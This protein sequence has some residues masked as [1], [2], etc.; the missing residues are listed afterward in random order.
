MPAGE[1]KGLRRGGRRGARPGRAEPPRRRR[2]ADSARG[3]RYPGDDGRV[4][5]GR[6]DGRRWPASRSS[7]PT[8][9]RR[10]TRSSAP[11]AKPDATPRPSP[12][13]PRN[14]STRWSGLTVR[15]SSGSPPAP[16]GRE[17][18]PRRWPAGPRR[19]RRGRPTSS[20]PIR[21]LGQRR[22]RSPADRAA[23]RRR[24]LR[25]DSA[26]PS[27]CT[28][29]SAATWAI[30]TPTCAWRARPSP[31]CPG[32]DWSPLRRSRRPQPLGG[33]AAAIV[34]QPDGAGGD[35][36]RA[37]GAA[38]G[39]ARR[40][41]IEPGES[42]ASGGGRARWT[43][44]SFATATG[45]STS[46]TLSFPIPSCPNRDFWQRELAELQ[47]DPMNAEGRPL[48]VLDLTAMKAAGRRDRGAHLLRRGLRPPAR[49]RRRWTCCSSATR[50]NQVLGR[51]RDDAQRDAGSD[52][53][54][55]GLRA[56]GARRGRW[57]S[58]ISRSS[59]IRSPSKTPSGTPA[60]CSRRAARTASSWRAGIRWPRRCARWWTAA[61]RSS[62]IS[63]SRR[64]RSTRSAGIGCRA[65]TPNA[66]MRSSVT[67]RRWRMPAR[68]PSC[69]SC[70]RRRWRRRIS[71][72]AHDSHHRDR[73]RTRMRRPGAGAPRHARAQRAVQSPKFLKHYAR[74]GE[75]V[76]QASRQFAQDVRDGKYPGPEHSFSR[77][78]AGR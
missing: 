44:T 29:R 71:E 43:S 77:S 39:A 56:D 75:T 42:A 38:G 9:R 60:G 21:E 17:A 31:P 16:P 54:S 24:D 36:A 18:T 49:S 78:Q 6:T 61:Y 27:G 69:S 53:L 15:R 45:A 1:G 62:A 57:C 23:L 72:V 10:S 50:C 11:P 20:A 47:A 55:R 51:P 59:P 14:S 2:G 8:P 34:P 76:R 13:R 41:R 5:D 37:A 22:V 66:P 63:V 12:S 26:R 65:G 4:P 19:R 28:S 7:A 48:H 30:G 58:W 74:A 67:R 32:L 35:R 46:R 68:A 64:S 40:S 70:C 33:H 3:D 52:D 73:G 25:G